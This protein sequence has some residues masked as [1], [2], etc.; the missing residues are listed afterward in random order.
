MDLLYLRDQAIREGWIDTPRYQEAAND[1]RDGT[2]SLRD[3]LGEEGYDRFLYATGQPNRLAITTVFD[4]SPAQTSGLQP[5][6]M[7]VSYD[8]VPVRSGRDVRSAT[9]SGEPG[10][11]VTMQVIRNGESIEVTI[12][13]GPIGIQMDGVSVAPN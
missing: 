11:L 4:S 12:P 6:D 5:G 8:G 2:L 7:I 1:L 9:T 3:E 13:R 10:E